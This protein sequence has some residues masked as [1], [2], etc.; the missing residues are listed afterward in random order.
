MII[1]LFASFNNEHTKIQ[2]RFQQ[3]RVDCI[4]SATIEALAWAKAM[5][6]GEGANT[7]DNDEDS[8][9]GDKKV[10]F[11]IYSV[12]LFEKKTRM[13]ALL[14]LISQLIRHSVKIYKNYSDALL[15]V[16]PK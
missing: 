7:L 8:S 11:N 16:K 10:K 12:S 13:K 14:V 1:C 3:G 2:F 5:C 4:R 9:K 15:L 6:Q